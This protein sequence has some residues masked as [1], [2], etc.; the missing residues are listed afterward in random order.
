LTTSEDGL[1]LPDRLQVG[2]QLI[3]DATERGRPREAGRHTAISGRICAL[4]TE[5]GEPARPYTGEH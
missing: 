3:R 2:Q 5:L 1:R 4:L